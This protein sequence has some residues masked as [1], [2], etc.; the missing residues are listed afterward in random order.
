MRSGAETK[1]PVVASGRSESPR[2]SESRQVSDKVDVFVLKSL[3]SSVSLIWAASL[4][5]RF[6]GAGI[7]S[8]AERVS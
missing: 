5:K 6:G 1:A 7:D 3:P 4:S 8:S 2:I